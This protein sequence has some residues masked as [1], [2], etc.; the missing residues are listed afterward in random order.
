MPNFSV[1]WDEKKRS[2]SRTVLRNALKWTAGFV[3]ISRKGR[4]RVWIRWID[5]FLAAVMLLALS[6]IMI[7]QTAGQSGAA[8]SLT[9][10]VPDLSGVWENI[11]KPAKRFSSTVE[12]SLQPWAEA[13][14][15][16]NMIPNSTG[17]LERD[18]SSEFGGCF[19]TGMPRLMVE[20]TPFE[21]IQIRGRVIFLFERDYAV[22]HIWTDG[23]KL[24]E[25]P[26]P[27]YMGS[28]VGKWEG[29]TLVVETVGLKDVT[30]LDPP[31]HPHSDALH[32]A[33]RIRRVSH[34]KLQVDWTFADPKAFTKAWTGQLIYELHPDWHL[35]EFISCQDRLAHGGESLEQKAAKGELV[36]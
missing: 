31:G 10:P 34:D 16:A 23:R 30:W 28:S 26:D 19:P 6:P 17:R 29:D 25:D 1:C 21:I 15:K 5:S 4:L 24:P 7:A 11:T 14:W 12:P 35:Q 2:L 33:E 20:T 13:K 18:P 22:R 32:I 9:P 36:K 27:T 3:P 8:N